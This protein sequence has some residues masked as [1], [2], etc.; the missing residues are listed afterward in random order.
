LSRAAIRNPFFHVVLPCLTSTQRRVPDGFFVELFD[1]AIP[2]HADLMP[3][4]ER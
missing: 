1:T 3:K 2:R 4:A